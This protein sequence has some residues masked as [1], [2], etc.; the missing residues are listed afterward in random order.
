MPAFGII[1]RGKKN[2]SGHPGP[3]DLP[4][5]RRC[6]WRSKAEAVFRFRRAEACAAAPLLQAAKPTAFL[7]D[8]NVISETRKRRPHGVVL[9]WIRT[10]PDQSLHVS[11]VPTGEIQAGIELTRE[12]DTDKT[13]EIEAW[14]DQVAQTFNV[15]PVDAPIFRCWA[16]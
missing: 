12:Q 4:T 16:R 6:C 13:K 8:T 7:L 14:L 3:F 9:A 11:A 5:S 2:Q 15:L 1:D 10:V